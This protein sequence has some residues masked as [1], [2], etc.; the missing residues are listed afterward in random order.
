MMERYFE[1][2]EKGASPEEAMKEASVKIGKAIVTSGL[3]TVFG[4]A[5]LIASP[6]SMTSNFGFI[7]VMDVILALLASFIVFPAVI[8]LL[9]KHRESRK[10]RKSERALQI[11]GSDG[12]IAPKEA[13]F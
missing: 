11:V 10:Y 9:D 4:F 7:T 2:K 12:K 13:A 8:V 3:T 1:E 5:A 6:F